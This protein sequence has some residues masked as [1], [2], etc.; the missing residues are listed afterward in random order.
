MTLSLIL[1]GCFAVMTASLSGKLVTVRFLGDIIERNLSFLV[2]FAAGVL[3]VVVYGLF[4][5]VVEHAGSLR[6][7]LPWIV[8]G[9][10]C[11]LVAFRYVPNFHHHHDESAGEHAHD[12]ID[13]N[14]VLMSDAI[15][16]TTDGIV[17][18]AAFSASPLLGLMTTAS[19]FLHELVQEV[20]EF[21][22]LRQAGL[23]T[24]RALFLNF[25]ASSTILVGALGGYFLIEQFEALE[26]PMLGIAA[27][28]YLIVVFHDLIPHSIR[29]STKGIEY[30]KHLSWFFAGLALMA[31]VVTLFSHGHEESS[32]VAFARMLG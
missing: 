4:Q 26:L 2:S 17:L 19:V 27:G 30:V 5:E 1:L 11:I 9:A 23:S 3:L 32:L 18:A 15:H 10:L 24:A 28:S 21:F 16:N 6:M 29:T 8:A 12:T 22:V 14:R 13:A 31:I 7:G 25:L 20:S